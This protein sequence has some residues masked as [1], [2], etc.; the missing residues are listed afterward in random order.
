MD[1][2]AQF[3]RIKDAICTITGA[4]MPR[5]G[6][7]D[8]VRCL[9]YDQQDTVL[10][11]ATGYGKSAVLYAFS[12]L[13]DKITVQIVPLTKLG[14]NQ[15]DDIARNVPNSRPIWID[16]DTHLKN[17]RVWDEVRA[18]NYTHVLLSPEQALNPKFKSVMRSPRFHDALGLFA[19]DELHCVGEWRDFRQ[20]YTYLHT[21]RS[22]LPRRIPWFGCTA[23]LDK[24]NQEFIFKHAGFDPTRLKIIR[25]SVDRPEISIVVQPLLRGSLRDHRRL[26]FLL[27]GFTPETVRQ[28]PK[29]IIYLDSKPQLI[30]A[31]Y[32]LIKY[33]R[34]KCGFTKSFAR[35]V[36]RR[37]DADV[38]Q[39]DKDIIFRDFASTDTDCRVIIA[40]VSLG[41]GMDIPDVERVVQFGLPPDPSLSDVWQRIR[42]AMRKKD[43]QGTAILFIP[44]WAFDHLGSTENQAKQPTKRVARRGARRPHA[45]VVA[46]RLRQMTLV[47]RDDEVGSQ[48][49]DASQASV[50]SSPAAT[51][52]VDELTLEDSQ[53][54]QCLFDFNKRVKWSKSDLSQR[55]KLDP[56]F[57]SFLNASCFRK[58]A[59][60]YLQEPDDLGLEYKRAVTPEQCCNACNHSLGRIP[61][62]PPREKGHEKPSSGSLAGVAYRHLS[63][64]CQEQAQ[65]LVHIEGR[66]FDIVAEMWLDLKL[67]YA[68]ARLFSQA[69]R[70]KGKQELPFKD[71]QGLVQNVPELKEWEH[72]EDS[73]VKLV[74][75]CIGWPR[76]RRGPGTGRL[77]A[78]VE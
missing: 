41:M 64:W 53:D 22:F 78:I 43:G 54:S 6:Q 68:V 24:D 20:D 34:R 32:T 47:E 33:M 52:T 23:T 71:I 48:A 27:E 21:L 14:E 39:T 28:I 73:G 58:F 29:T 46:S 60:E 15:R 42:R 76:R 67:Q 17:P 55:E 63:S 57:L 30:A 77:V 31:R 61:N 16:A 1:A 13:T 19:I 36:I 4:Q 3:D 11:A 70:S 7:I 59:L 50:T 44:Y 5:L 37:Y 66:R 9:V 56:V 51:A 40:T 49:S 18:G 8:A 62:L 38:S 74:E 69:K 75:F 25:A 72:L 26:Q 2:H 10:V 35:K 45:P 65:N 12:A